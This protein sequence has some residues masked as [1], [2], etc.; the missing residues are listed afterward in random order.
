MEVRKELYHE[1]VGKGYLVSVYDNGDHYGSTKCYDIELAYGGRY[2]ATLSAKT[3]GNTSLNGHYNTA[4]TQ[5]KRLIFLLDSLDA[6]YNVKMTC[7]K[8]MTM[9]EPKDNCSEA[10]YDAN[11]KIQMLEVWIDEQMKFYGDDVYKVFKNEFRR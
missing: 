9:S 8:N 4:L 7:S 3:I 5:M 11:A 6:E 1:R 10:W 2:I